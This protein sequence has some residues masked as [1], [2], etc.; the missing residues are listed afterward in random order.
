MILSLND[1]VNF[2]LYAKF[3]YM[4]QLSRLWS[5]LVVI[6]LI[7]A[8]I[9]LFFRYNRP[10]VVLVMDK[11][12]SIVYPANALDGFK[13]NL[14]R[15]GYNLKFVVADSETFMDSVKLETLLSGYSDCALMLTTPVISTAVRAGNIGLSSL[16]KG[17]A[18]GMTTDTEDCF[19]IVLPTDS[20]NMPEGT[21]YLD[22]I[23]KTDVGAL[24][25]PDLGMSIIPLLK[26]DKSNLTVR[27]AVTV[28]EVR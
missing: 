17:L 27:E 8:A 24:V 9:F 15:E 6:V 25:Y 22:A 19:D 18:V 26:M 20:E 23:G 14:D 5:K 12:F 13:K 1:C 28:Y 10:Q 4:R 21:Y 16:I 3:P 7:F 11:S 2:Q